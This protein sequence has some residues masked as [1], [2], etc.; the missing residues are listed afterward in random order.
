MV[1]IP[2]NRPPT[3]P[4]EMLRDEFLIPMNISQRDLANAIHVPYLS[5]RQCACK[6]KTR[7]NPEYRLAFGQVFRSISG[8]LAQPTDSMGFIQSASLRKK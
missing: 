6:S 4:G 5:A 2:T 7:R 8:F 3:H 1:R